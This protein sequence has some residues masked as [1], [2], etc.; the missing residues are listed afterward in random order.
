MNRD[1]MT[2]QLRRCIGH[3]NF[4][5]LQSWIKYRLNF[6]KFYNA[7]SKQSPTQKERLWYIWRMGELRMVVSLTD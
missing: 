5:K 3:Y 7:N 1:K 6:R 2:L 4:V